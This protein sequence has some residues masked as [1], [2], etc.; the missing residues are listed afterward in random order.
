MY[1][2]GIVNEDNFFKYFFFWKKVEDILYEGGYNFIVLRVGI[3]VGSGS[4]FFEIICDLCEKFFIMVVFK[5]LKIK[6]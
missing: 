2:S 5:W 3:V 6:I 4:F 1:L